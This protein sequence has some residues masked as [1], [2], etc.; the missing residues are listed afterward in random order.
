MRLHKNLVV[1]VIKVL[2]GVFNQNL[3]A[4]KTIEKVLKHDKRWGS[5][6]R[7]FIAETS[8]DIVRWKRLYSEIA[9]A[10]S[11]Y[12][13]KE[14][15]KI[16]AVWAVLKGIQLPNW[17]ELNETPNRRIKGKFD[18]LIKIRKFRE[19]IPDWLDEIG[20]DELGEKNWEKELNAL[21]QKASVII[22]TNTL[23]TTIDKLQ[24]ILSDEDIQTEKIKGFPEALKLIIRKN[25]FLTDAFKNGLFEI[26]DASSQLVAPFLQIEDG[27][28]ICDVCAGAGGKT[29]HLSALSGNKGQIIAMDIYKNKL[30]ELKRRAK[31]NN[32]FNIETRVIENN[33]P[34]KRLYGKID[35]LLIDSPCSGLGV[36]KRNPGSKWNLSL[37]FLE[38]I[39]FTQQEIL[40]KYAP[41]IKKDGKL[42]YATCS[43][44]P[45]ENEQQIDEFLKSDIG[46]AFKKEDEKK[47]SP[48]QT[49]FD[50]F[51][52]ARLS[53]K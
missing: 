12:K 14:L 27:M 49:G 53:Y 22:R 46:K 26:Q 31:R 44:L 30:H 47:V 6:D 3:Y 32:A 21:N 38:K 52:M 45:S 2:D 5:R 43:I 4:D 17:P 28:K 41:M 33:K 19:S 15:W 16:F 18:E 20:L 50:G 34:I 39:R 36:L 42:V 48:N 51:Y 29:L 8:Y 1:A 11:P 7:G 9:E 40:K 13:H 35:R 23:N 10:K 24:S 37:D 25:L